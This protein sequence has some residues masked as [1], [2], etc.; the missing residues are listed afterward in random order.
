MAGR[1]PTAG[2]P[3]RFWTVART[4][5]SEGDPL[6]AAAPLCHH[7]TP[8]CPSPPAWSRAQTDFL[9]TEAEKVKYCTRHKG[10][11]LRSDL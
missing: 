7:T 5:A 1:S 11:S 3:G 10:I 6:L 9:R 4:G 8:P 2:L